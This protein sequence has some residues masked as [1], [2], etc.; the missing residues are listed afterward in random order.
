MVV[1][2]TDIVNERKSWGGIGLW[3]TLQEEGEVGQCEFCGEE[4]K[5]VSTEDD[6]LLCECCYRQMLQDEEGMPE[7]E[8]RECGRP[9]GDEH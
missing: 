8:C 7:D 4:G 3:G 5:V 6:Q 2:A 1:W 9:C